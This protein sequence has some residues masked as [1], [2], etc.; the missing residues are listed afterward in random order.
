L[1]PH[2]RNLDPTN[3]SLYRDIMALQLR[4]GDKHA[5]ANTLRLLQTQLASG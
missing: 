3:E 2:T 4:A 1:E 5:A